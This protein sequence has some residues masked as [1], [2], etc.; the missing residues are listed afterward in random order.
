MDHSYDHERGGLIIKVPAELDHH[1]A[2]KL[3]GETEYLLNRYPTRCITFDFED[4]VFMDSSGIG[5]ILGRCRSMGVS[6]GKVCAAHLNPQ[7]QKIFTV[8]GL[9]KVIEVEEEVRK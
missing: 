5:V 3:K 2:E 7:L 6:G 8:S 4:T 9:Y 1:A